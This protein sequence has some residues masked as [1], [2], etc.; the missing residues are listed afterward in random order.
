M[1]K[2]IFIIFFIFF[3]GCSL[4][5]DSFYP[6][7]DNFTV[8]SNSSFLS[9]EVE[10]LSDQHIQVISV[11]SMKKVDHNPVFKED[12]AQGIETNDSLSTESLFS[13]N[14]MY[15]ILS[16]APDKYWFW[17]DRENIGGFVV[18]NKRILEDDISKVVYD[19]SEK[20]A[21]LEDDM[22]PV[23]WLNKKM[24]IYGP[25]FKES[26]V[27]PKGELWNKKYAMAYFKFQL[28]G[29]EDID[30][31]SKFISDRFAFSF[32]RPFH[33]YMLEHPNYFIFHSFYVKSP[34][35]MMQEYKFEKAIDIDTSPIWI[36]TGKDSVKSYLA[37]RY[38]K[39]DDP[40][41]EVVFHFDPTNT[42][43]LN[44]EEFDEFGR[45]KVLYK[46]DYKNENLNFTFPK[47]FITFEDHEE[48]FEGST[49]NPEFQYSS[50]D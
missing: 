22:F 18:E 48:F 31:K 21:Y 42:T 16:K 34:F 6:E 44:I 10:T 41:R 49:N 24:G 45:S 7:K 25:E 1:I 14:L 19:M 11:E 30:K 17:N 8:S 47:Y 39:K 2:K 23:S 15:D 27:D 32:W 35:D 36:N 46:F 50:Y 12:L 5:Q 9:E 33:E 38:V 37:A 20:T 26:G 13:P 4:G 29:I 28:T 40:S 3:I 43:A